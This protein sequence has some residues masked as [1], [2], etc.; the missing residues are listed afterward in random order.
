MEV[1]SSVPLSIKLTMV[2]LSAVERPN[3]MVNLC[4]RHSYLDRTILLFF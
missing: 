1:A 3:V 4:I 2:Y